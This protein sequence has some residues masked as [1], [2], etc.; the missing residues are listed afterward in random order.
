MFEDINFFLFETE[1]HLKDSIQKSLSSNTFKGEINS[2]IQAVAISFLSLLNVAYDVVYMSRHILGALSFSV[3]NLKSPLKYASTTRNLVVVLVEFA[4]HVGG[5]IMGSIVGVI[6]PRVASK[7]FLPPDQGQLETRSSNMTPKQAGKLYQMLSIV[8]NLF[9][10]EEI[11][12]IMTGGTQLGALRHGGIIPWDDD[13]DLFVL[14]QD[15]EKIENLKQQLNAVG[16]D[17][18]PCHLGFKIFD[19]NGT[20]VKESNLVYKYPFIDICLAVEI[21]GKI[22]YENEHFRTHYA[23]EYFTVGEWNSRSLQKFGP[24]QLCGAREPEKF[25]KRAFGDTSMKYGFQLLNHRTFKI[26]IPQ[27]V[28]LRKDETTGKCKSIRYT[29]FK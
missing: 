17:I 26:E 10:K 20:S 7:Y 28:Y 8:H 19:N 22:T 5:A 27:K 24:I 2:R 12:C 23:G 18:I 1:F 3:V 25:C 15:R 13:A 6:S 9:E 29:N 11:S 4:R 21:N 14:K 16:L